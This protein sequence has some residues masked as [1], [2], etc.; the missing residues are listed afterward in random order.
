[1]SRFFRLCTLNLVA[2][3]WLGG[4][5]F[6]AEVHEVFRPI[7]LP[8]LFFECFPLPENA[9]SGDDYHRDGGRVR[10]PVSGS[11]ER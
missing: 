5:T 6:Q 2:L 7:E 8:D 11:Y 3:H 4:N 10:G 1:M 9:A